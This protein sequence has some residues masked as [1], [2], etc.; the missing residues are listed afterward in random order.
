VRQRDLERLKKQVKDEVQI[1]NELK[2]ERTRLREQISASKGK[3]T[4]RM[5]SRW[6]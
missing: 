3:S 4:A 6:S 2:K 5:T 1:V